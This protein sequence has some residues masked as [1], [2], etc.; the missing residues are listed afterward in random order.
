MP[1]VL[2]APDRE[3]LK[4]VSIATISTCLYRAGVKVVV[5]HGVRPLTSTQP[6]M[7]GEAF[8]LRFIPMRDDVGGMSS[9]GA[10][11][12]VH[13]Q[14]FEDCP[15]GH[16]LVMDTRGETHGCCCGDLLIGRLKARGCAGVVTDG[17]FR[18][19]PDIALL[20]FPAYQRCAVPAPSFG[21]LQAVELNVPIGCSDVAVY[22]GDV[23]VGDAEG[24]VVIPA[25]MAQRI[26]T[27][28]YAMTQYDNFAA[29]EIAR[30]RSVVGLY[31]PT[32]ASRLEF[33][34]WQ[35]SR[36]GDTAGTEVQKRK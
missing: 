5:P 33:K 13:Q 12:N 17:G 28:A 3:R 14:A 30:G 16:V 21:R 15:A 19:T 32:D 29:D 22:P 34:R 31:P 24:V 8:T 23:I 25:A 11:P 36:G 2:T 27:E 18:D 6:R 20:D 10:G 9:Y 7:V 26:A 35:Q 1:N 4:Q